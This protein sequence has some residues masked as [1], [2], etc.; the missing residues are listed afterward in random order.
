M[1]VLEMWLYVPLSLK[2]K[3]LL[4]EGVPLEKPMREEG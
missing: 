1:E 4:Y 2:D 3:A